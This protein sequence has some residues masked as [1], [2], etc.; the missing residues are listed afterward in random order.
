MGTCLLGK[1]STSRVIV[2]NISSS[3]AMW[4]SRVSSGMHTLIF[5]VSSDHVNLMDKLL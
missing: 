5:V 1:T 4:V 2:S 3:A